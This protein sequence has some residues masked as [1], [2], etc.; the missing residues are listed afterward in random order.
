MFPLFPFCARWGAGKCAP[1]PF[2]SNRRRN[3][4]FWLREAVSPSKAASLLL[5]PKMSGQVFGNHT[6]A[7]RRL[8]LARFR[9]RDQTGPFFRGLYGLGKKKRSIWIEDA[10]NTHFALQYAF[11]CQS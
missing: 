11:V 9:K 1:A 8:K 5:L 10:M 6:L 2:G 7:F 3:F 4:N